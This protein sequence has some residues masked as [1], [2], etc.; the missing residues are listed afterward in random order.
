MWT[1]QVA[2]VPEQAPC[3]PWNVDPEAAAAVRV[4]SMPSANEALQLPPQSM[5]AGDDVMVPDPSPDRA[6]VKECV[7]GGGGG[8]SASKEACTEASPVIAMLQ[9]VPVHAPPKPLK[10]NPDAGAAVSVTFAPSSKVAT[11]LLPQSIPAGDEEID[12][13][14]LTDTVSQCLPG[15]GG[16][17]EENVAVAV[18]LASRTM[19][20]GPVPLQSSL[21]DV[22]PLLGSGAAVSVTRVPAGNCTVQLV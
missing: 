12:P 16:T 14:P 9:V 7:T 11:H 18:R 22:K 3:Q 1:E 17:R 21:Q 6:T 20:H 4:T 10:W 19:V 5:P 8:A 2:A 13:A 15:G